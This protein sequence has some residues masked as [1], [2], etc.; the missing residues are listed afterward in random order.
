VA[1][2]TESLTLLAFN[3]PSSSRFFKRMFLPMRTRVFFGTLHAHL[4]EDG[5]SSQKSLGVANGLARHF[6]GTW[7]C[8]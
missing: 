5:L 7:F 3:A 2:E 4:P 1:Q 8:S 6:D